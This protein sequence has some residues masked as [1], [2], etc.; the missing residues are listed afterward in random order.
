MIQA[1]GGTGGSFYCSMSWT[2]APAPL[3]GDEVTADAG[4]LDILVNNAG[5]GHVGTLDDD[6]RG[7]SRSSLRVNVRGVFNVSQGVSAGDA[8]ARTGQHREHRVGRRSGRH[9]RS[10]GLLHDEIRRRRIDE[11]HGARPRGHRRARELHL[12]GTGARRRLSQAR[13]EGV[14]GSG[15]RAIARCPR[16]SRSAGWGRPE[17][18]AAAALYLASDEAAFV[19]GS[20]LMIDGGWIG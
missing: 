18:I 11:E 14:S 15:A 7:G 3:C 19:T 6:K 2:K 16:H 17:E 20:A 9:T 1:S 4:A 8:R 12:P 5:I 13:L 10:A